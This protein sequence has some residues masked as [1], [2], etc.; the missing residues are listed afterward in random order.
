MSALSLRLDTPALA[1]HYERASVDRQFKA[2]KQLIEK[3]EIGAGQTVLDVG[4]GTGLLAAHV[5]SLVGHTGRVFAVDPLPLRIEIAKRKARPNLTFLVGD[6]YD[7]SNFSDEKFDVVYLN[8]VFHW[9]A[10]KRQPLSNFF[11]VLKRG[12]RLGISTGSKDHP[13]PVHAL[14]RKVL[15]RDGYSAFVAPSTGLPHRVSEAE[16]AQLLKESG[17]V[18]RQLELASHRVVHTSAE[19]ALEHHQASSFGNL[20]GHLPVALQ[21]RARQELVAELEQLRT[22]EGIVVEGARIFAVADKV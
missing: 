13:S 19:A 16:L 6:A 21:Q 14:Q 8:A 4:A 1:E 17:F 22:A 18:V 3:I 9:L 12:G 10:E 2:G 7:L 15:A 11:R 5:S 20:L